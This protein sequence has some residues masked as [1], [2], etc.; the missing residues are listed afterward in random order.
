MATE[1]PV[2]QVLTPT[3]NLAPI[4]AAS[5]VDALAVGQIGVFNF[6]TGLSVDGTVPA[7]CRDIFIAVG[8]SRSGGSTLEDIQKSAGQVIQASRNAK[9]VTVKGYNVPVPKI[10]EV[11]GFGANCETDYAIK[12]E[13]RSQQGYGVAGYNQIS[14]T[15]TFRT[16]C[17]SQADC[18]TCPQGDANELALGMINEINSQAE[19]WATASLFVNILN[20]TITHAATGDGSLVVTVGA[21]TFSVPILTADSATVVA[22]KVVAFIN[23]VTTSAYKA[24]N[25]GAVISVYPIKSKTANTDLIGITTQFGVTAG[26]FTVGNSSIAD[27]TALAAF[28]LAHPGVDASIRITANAA[29]DVPFNGNIPIKYYNGTYQDIIVSLVDGFRCNGSATI[30]QQM[31]I[32]DGSGREL[33]FMEYEAGGFNGKPGPY[34]VSSVTGLQKGNFDQFIDSAAKYTQVVLEYDQFSVGGWLEYLNNLRTIIAIPCADSTTLQGLF[35]ILDLIFTQFG[36]MTNDVAGI[37]CTNTTT[38][39]LTYA[40]DGIETLS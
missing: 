19:K 20:A 26:T 7:D 10:I 15:F 32:E 12:I 5:R 22:T 24:S 3:G 38:N 18:V 17:C 30:A 29:A 37:D 36:A 33:A 4:A 6:H 16:G 11:T 23:G 21:E 8:I 14:E 27:A 9:A 40:T 1:N 34:R 31:T 28:K 2:F 35:T 13:L 39:T 25:T